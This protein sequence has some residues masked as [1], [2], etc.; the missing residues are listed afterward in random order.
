M[1]KMLILVLA[2]VILLYGCSNSGE[3][4]IKAPF[5]GGSGTQ[6]DPYQL[7]T[8][9]DLWE[10]AEKIQGEEGAH[11]A[12]ANYILTADID[13]G[14]NRQWEPIGGKQDFEG[15]LDGDGYTIRGIVIRYKDP[16]AGQKETAIGMF[17]I[18]RGKVQNLTIGNSTLNSDGEAAKAGMFAGK[19]IGGTLDNCHTEDTV[20]VSGEYQIGGICGEANKDSVI[21]NC[22]NAA[23]V[24]ARSNIGCAAGIV[25]YTSCEI[26]NCSNTGNITSEGDA[27]GIANTAGRSMLNCTNAGAVSARSYAAGIVCRFSD[28]ALNTSMND[29]TVQISNCTNS[30]SVTSREDPAGGIA[31]CARTGSINVCANSGTV[32]SAKETGGILGYF[33]Q[34]V[35]G[36]S[37]EEFTIADCSNTGEITSTENYSSGGICGILYGSTTRIRLVNCSNR[38]TV[39]ASGEKDVL[40]SGAEAGGMVG[41]ASVRTL[42]MTNCQNAGSVTG[43]AMSGGMIGHVSP[44]SNLKDVSTQLLLT[45]CK[46]TGTI[47]VI[48]P[49]GL[50]KTIYAG[51]MVGYCRMVQEEGST[52]PVFAQ[53]VME[54]CTNE[55]MLKG[56][57][58]DVTLMTADLCANAPIP[59]TP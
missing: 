36:T 2:M 24:T 50:K 47:T 10:F 46:N 30:G 34:S 43:Y 8:P 55:G 20:Q 23:E 9:E 41:Q 19:L 15:C 7:R 13:L 32:T 16:L 56:D 6:E 49:G 29:T 54:N 44:D 12:Q 5:S 25:S 22:S 59:E 28:G 31:A 40:V 14:G 52:L 45:D 37:C 27:A 4:E 1:K 57:E 35:F 18:L 26:T 51:G 21:Q 3:V 58:T 17:R 42:E 11:Y 33:Q 48:A 53:V 39:H 38:G